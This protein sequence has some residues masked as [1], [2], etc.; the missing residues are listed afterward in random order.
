MY[1]SV[2][3]AVLHGVEGKLILV[4]ADVSNGLPGFSMVGYLS[5]EV[6]EAQDRVWAALHNQGIRLEPKKIVINMAPAG[7]RKSGSAFDLPVAVAV[8]A[9]YGMIRQEN[10]EKCLFLGELGL[11]GRIKGVPGVL[12]MV[13][14][15]ARAGCKSCIIPEENINEGLLIPGITVYGAGDFG[16]VLEFFTRGTGLLP[17]A[18]ES[19][20]FLQKREGQPDFAEVRGQ[21]VCRR[22]AEIAV[23]GFHNLLLSGQPGTGKTMIARRIPTILPDLTREE[24]LEITRIY[25]AAGMLDAGMGL[26][27]MRPFRAPHHTVSPQALAGGGRIPCPG[28]ITLA[29]R[30]VLYLDELPE[31]KRDTLEIL[32]QPMED[33]V[34][35]I[36]RVW[37]NY[38]FP[39]RFITVASMNPCKCGFF[40][41]RNRCRCTISEVRRYQD[42]IGQPLLDRFDL[43]ARTKPVAFDELKGEQRGEPSAAIRERVLQARERQ[44]SRY[45]SHPFTFNGE[46]PTGMLDT[47]CRLGFKEERLMDRLF[48]GGKLSARGYHRVLKTARTIADLEGKERISLDHLSEAVCYR[49]TEGREEA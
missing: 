39:A 38:C 10:T 8:L 37:G 27:R 2:M 22:A 15:A 29:H 11:D 14:E 23:A 25:S 4:E 9:A 44:E 28:E 45:R 34:I 48:T 33:G 35:Q 16:E 3:S 43:C 30:G 12:A 17:A 6:K 46:I 1:S 42:R 24:A 21:Q 40:P 31:F 26:I 20:P 19:D 41:D 36:S 5:S 13:S 47:C 49:L 7:L 32:R 18:R